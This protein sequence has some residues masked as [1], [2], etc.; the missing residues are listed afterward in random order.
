MVKKHLDDSL[1]NQIINLHQ[2]NYKICD[3][4]EI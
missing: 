1:K 4:T 3:I 2:R